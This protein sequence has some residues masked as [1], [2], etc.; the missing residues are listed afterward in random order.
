MPVRQGNQNRNG[1]EDYDLACYGLHKRR[2][3]NSRMDLQSNPEESMWKLAVK[4][5]SILYQ[6]LQQNHL[7]IMDNYVKHFKIKIWKNVEKNFNF[8]KTQY[9]PGIFL[10]LPTK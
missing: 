5:L 10:R 9:L 7:K 8:F 6:A 4:Y 2:T 1:E 3:L